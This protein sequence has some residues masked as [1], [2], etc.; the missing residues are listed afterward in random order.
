[1]KGVKQSSYLWAAGNNWINFAE[2]WTCCDAPVADWQPAGARPV[3]HSPFI[4]CCQTFPRPPPFQGRLI[5]QVFN[6]TK[7]H[8]HHQ[9]T[10]R[11]FTAQGEREGEERGERVGVWWD[12]YQLTRWHAVLLQWEV[13]HCIKK[14]WR[15]LFPAPRICRGF[16]VWSGRGSDRVRVWSGQGEG[17]IIDTDSHPGTGHCPEG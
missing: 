5:K 10:E 16:C 4:C 15:T 9:R 14:I 12:E 7:Q 6:K 2:K 8:L 11:G 13:W 3:Y 1:M 17:L